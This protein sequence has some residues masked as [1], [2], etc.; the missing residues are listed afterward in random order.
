LRTK[1]QICGYESYKFD[2]Y[3]DLSIPIPYTSSSSTRSLFS[4]KSKVE[5]KVVKLEECLNSFIQEEEME[6]CGYKC[7]KCKSEDDF[8]N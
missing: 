8:M 3:M 5:D 4:Y 6:K 1:C 7:N 2:N